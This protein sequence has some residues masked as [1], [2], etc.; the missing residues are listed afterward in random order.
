M[1][2]ISY[3]LIFF[4]IFGGKKYIIRISTSDQIKQRAGKIFNQRPCAYK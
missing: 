3:M 2:D 1:L 4:T